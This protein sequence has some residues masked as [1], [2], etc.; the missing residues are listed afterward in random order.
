METINE[1]IR[2]AMRTSQLPR[3]PKVPTAEDCMTKRVVTFR[4]DQH[5]T[6]VIDILLKEHLS[7]GPVCDDHHRMLGML[8]E[9]DCL[10][11]IASGAYDGEYH[12]PAR[13]V[14][15]IMS[16]RTITVKLSDSIYTMA[17]MFDQ[18]NVRRL[19]VIDEGI[20]VG[21]VSRRDMLTHIKHLFR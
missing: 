18:H 1:S 21:Q 13:T 17:Q 19:P 7:G 3:P 15:E 10:R 2:V 11:A 9:M 16:R 20:V 4:E 14:R 5:I 6:D 8:S 12:Q